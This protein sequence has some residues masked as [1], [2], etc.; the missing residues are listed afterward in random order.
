ML[1]FVPLGYFASPKMSGVIDYLQLSRR[2]Q[3]AFGD[4]FGYFQK[5]GVF[6]VN[7]DFFWANTSANWANFIGVI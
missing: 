7:N 3:R 4:T 1:P 5:H 2:Y 6:N